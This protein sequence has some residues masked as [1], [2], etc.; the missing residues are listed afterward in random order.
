[1]DWFSV[2]VGVAVDQPELWINFDLGVSLYLPQLV[3]GSSLHQH[4]A[5]SFALQARAT[6]GTIKHTISK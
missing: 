3:F 4:S 1:M 5:T 2:C 6:S